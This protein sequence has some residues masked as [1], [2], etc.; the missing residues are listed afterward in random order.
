MTDR[1]FLTKKNRDVLYDRYEGS[2]G[3][4][5]NQESRIRSRANNA[6]DEL[7]AVADSGVIDNED[8][9]EADQ[10]YQLLVALTIERD[11][12]GSDSFDGPHHKQIDDAFRLEVLEAV[13][14][15]R[16]VYHRGERPET[17]ESAVDR[18]SNPD[19]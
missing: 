7:I 16:L 14:E 17:D 6:L 2:E 10:I 19:S 12:F 15:F 9:F 8:V 11:T 4:R 13:D 18:L 3:A 5:R 1:G